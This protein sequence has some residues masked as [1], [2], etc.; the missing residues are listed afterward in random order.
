MRR[1]LIF[2]V[3]LLVGIYL[4][5]GLWARQESDRQKHQMEQDKLN[6][7]F[8]ASH[9]PPLLT[10]ALHGNAIEMTRL[11][12]SGADTEAADRAGHT[13]LLIA[14]REGDIEMTQQLLKAGARV[15]A[16]DKIGR[17]SL[18]YALRMGRRLPLVKLLL[19]YGADAKHADRAGE[20]PL[21]MACDWA[22]TELMALFLDHG[23]EVN[24]HDRYGATP[25]MRVSRGIIAE[26]AGTK[27]AAEPGLTRHSAIKLLLD[28]GA[29]VNS[30]DSNGWSALLYASE[31]EPPEALQLLL[32]HGADPTITV[33][34]HNPLRNAA[35]RGLV[36]NLKV[37]LDTKAYRG[38]EA[39][40]EALMQATWTGHDA[41]VQF[42]IDQGADVNSCD[43]YG[44][45]P[46]M[47][48]VGSEHLT[49]AKLLL[50]RGA[51]PGMR[52]MK[53]RGPLDYAPP[54]RVRAIRIE[55][56]GNARMRRL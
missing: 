31:N 38:P 5:L 11:L 51:N 4:G 56:F 42:L 3:C 35:F 45:T 25:L 10:A 28:H 1:K 55:L 52:D 48:A 7:Q 33:R 43:Q 54:E 12:Q 21:M 37:L 30:R 23:A 34:G 24:V 16:Q 26:R 49:T 14:A 17:S 15:D 29:N 39:S 44:A 18:S 36:G 9:D 50:R 13:P 53:G 20:T 46:L 27:G 6:D 41:A 32:D 22:D 19:T 40:Q 8:L 47:V 2:F